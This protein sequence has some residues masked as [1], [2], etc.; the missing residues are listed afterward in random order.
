VQRRNGD[1]L[2]RLLRREVTPHTEIIISAAVGVVAAIP[3]A[4]LSTP[5]SAAL[6]GWEVAAAVYLVWVW[7]STWHMDPAETKRRATKF[8]L[9]DARARDLILL[10]AS[11]TSLAA[12]GFVV[13]RAGQTQGAEQV[14]QLAIGLASV[15]LSW[16]VVHTMYMLRYAHLYYLAS[17]RAVDFN[18]DTEPA[19]PDF[20]YLA[21]TI[22]M[23]FQVSDTPLATQTMRRTALRHA[24]LSYLFG[25]G[26]LAT[27]INL[28]ASIS[29][30]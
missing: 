26:I 22:G 23:T 10:S 18:T 28:V 14:L 12:V 20:A 29:S 5:L 7:S 21:F 2:A 25:T 11:I 13:A 4:L 8:D 27:T 6:L 15:V 9:Q 24:L 19:Y 1:A 30:K 3:L 16:A 17:K